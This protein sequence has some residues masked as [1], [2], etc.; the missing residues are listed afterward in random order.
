MDDDN[1][2]LISSNSFDDSSL[3]EI[4]EALISPLFFEHNFKKAS[5]IFLIKNII[6][7]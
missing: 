6:Q 7:I 1:S 2:L 3:D 4:N 5:V